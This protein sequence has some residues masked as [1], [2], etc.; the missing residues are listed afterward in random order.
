MRAIKKKARGRKEKELDL[1]ILWHVEKSDYKRLF[2]AG[3]DPTPQKKK[4]RKVV[5]HVC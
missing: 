4:K 3:S 5:G 1:G 2:K